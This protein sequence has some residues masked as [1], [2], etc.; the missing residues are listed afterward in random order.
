MTIS[1]VKRLVKRDLFVE[2]VNKISSP[3]SPT[4]GAVCGTIRALNGLYSPTC[5]SITVQNSNDEN[6]QFES[7]NFAPV[8]S[9]LDADWRCRSSGDGPGQ[10]W[11]SQTRSP[12]ED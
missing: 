8:C 1:C 10:A 4:F 11:S 12:G 6:S 3:M 9:L 5:Y 2:A 7:L